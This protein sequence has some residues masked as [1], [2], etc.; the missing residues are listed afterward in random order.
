MIITWRDTA[1]TEKG[2]TIRVLQ[3]TTPPRVVCVSEVIPKGLFIVSI[4]TAYVRRSAGPDVYETQ[5]ILSKDPQD[6]YNHHYWRCQNALARD[7]GIRL[8]MADTDHRLKQQH[9]VAWAQKPWYRRLFARKPTAPRVRFEPETP[10]LE[11]DCPEWDAFFE[12]RS[13][14]AALFTTPETTAE[15]EREEVQARERYLGRFAIEYP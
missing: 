2:H 13:A 6:A 9:D 15:A 4:D 10:W 1:T 7:K 5:L 14:F 12:T 8:A 11:R 3:T